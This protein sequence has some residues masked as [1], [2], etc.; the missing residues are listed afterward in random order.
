ME[1]ARW[2]ELR[3]LFDAVCD[4][5]S[6]Q[7]RDRLQALSDDPVLIDE[8]L[9]LLQAQTASFDRALRPLGELMAALP[10]AEL[11]VGDRLGQWQ[12]VERLASGGMGTV[13]V[14]ERADGLFRQRVAIKLLRGIGSDPAI[15]DRMAE[16]RR[17]LA[18]LGH[19]GIARLFDGGTTP[20]GHPYLVM[21]YIDGPPLDAHCRHHGLGLHERLKLFLRV[22]RAVQAAHQRLVV[23]CDLKPSNILVRD[24]VAPV[25]LDFGIARVLGQGQGGDDPSAF[26]TPA[27]ASPEQLAGATVDVTSDVFSLGVLL[28]ELL[29]RRTTGRGI[30][31]R[32]RPVPLPSVLAQE[33][34]GW[35]RAL[36]G[37]LD[38][39]TAKACALEPAQRYS[40]VEAFAGDI[41]R[42]LTHQPVAARTGT[43]SYLA[44]RWL[45]RRW[46]FVAIGL[47][48]ATLVGVFVWRLGAERDRAEREAEQAQLVSDFLVDA[49]DVSDPGM[50]AAD[51]SGPDARDIL[52]LAAAR[53]DAGT[54]DSPLLEARMQAVL[55]SA[56]RN[57]GH[58]QHAEARLQAAAEGFL[59]PE[60]DRPDLAG[61]ALAD[62]AGVLLGRQQ[63]ARAIPLARRAVQLL[64]GTGRDGWLADAHG[65]LGM[66]LGAHGQF[67]EARNALTTSIRLRARQTGPGAVEAES[68]GWRYLGYLHRQ[69]GE[70]Q[71]AE[72]AYDEALRIAREGGLHRIAERQALNGLAYALMMQ[73]RLAEARTRYGE[74]LELVRSLYGD[75]NVNVAIVHQSMAHVLTTLGEFAQAQVHCDRAIALASK[76][77]GEQSAE[78]AAALELAAV[79]DDA[80]GDPANALR[81]YRRALAIRQQLH[82]AANGNVWR[83]EAS[84]ARVLARQGDHEEAGRLVEGAIAALRRHLPSDRAG[85]ASLLATRAEWLLC[86]GDSDA[87]EHLLTTMD[88][89]ELESDPRL[90]VRRQALLAEL[91][92]LRGRW[93]SAAM[94]WREV[95][96]RAAEHFGPDS[97]V[98]M[99]YRLFHAEALAAAGEGEQARRQLRPVGAIFD[100]ELAPQAPLR[101]RHAELERRLAR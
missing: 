86:R 49:F 92:A 39:I 43:P 82:G 4:L 97:A 19:P 63:A 62:L 6:G 60:V 64:E 30:D 74:L 59:G 90:L 88:T 77:T 38:A 17:I 46:R 52:D 69:S 14:A 29:A 15:A 61:R 27:Y 20:S 53:L 1:A 67:D 84:I 71:R 101:Q 87:A 58:P 18:G 21:E 24:E 37:D 25:L 8:A 51:S 48:L 28:V 81:L 89:R 7:W 56:Y 54:V 32:D 35:S 5:P 99:K 76:L 98:T 34:R 12:L 68:R 78:F 100:R 93:P 75:E 44:G 91:E 41:E 94:L 10:E 26:C 50:R 96:D 23:H 85:E 9:A 70:L 66:A 95:V 40:T 57:L 65:A 79:I 47:T 3:Q 42:Y 31:H 33:D 55:G 11:Q 22:C 2:Q 16:E 13:F 73:G 83:L 36:R 72:Q 80:R 45:R